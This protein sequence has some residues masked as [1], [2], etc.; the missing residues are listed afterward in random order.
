MTRSNQQN[1]AEV[2]LGQFWTYALRRLKKPWAAM[3][4]V[5]LLVGEEAWKK[6]SEAA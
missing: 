4:Q 2:T 6:S 5:Q 1:K 3:L